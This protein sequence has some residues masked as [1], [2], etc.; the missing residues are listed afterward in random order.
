MTS[1]IPESSERGVKNP[2][3]VDLIYKDEAASFVVLQMI[4]DRAW[5][6]S[7]EQ[8]EELGEKFNNYIDYVLDGWFIKQYPQHA[9]QKVCLELI[10]SEEPSADILARLSDLARFSESVG[11]NFRHSR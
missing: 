2:K 7:K 8:L 5:D 4:E 9:A 11:L 3:I 1:S 10:Y 6:G